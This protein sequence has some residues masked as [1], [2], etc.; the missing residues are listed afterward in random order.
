MA[1]PAGKAGVIPP[2]EDGDTLDQVARVVLDDILYNVVQDLLSKTHMEEKLAR[3]A[4]ASIRV[5]KLASDAAD[6]GADSKPDVRI[7]TDAAIY[8]DGKTFFAQ[9]VTFLDFYTRQMERALE[10]LI[11]VEYIVKASIH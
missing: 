3:A 6:G 1:S 8:E 7:E 2:T 4:T 5:E 10:S 9:D 11:R